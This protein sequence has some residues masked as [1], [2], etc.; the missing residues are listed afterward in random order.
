MND[1]T[2]AI[3]V[4]LYIEGTLVAA[5]LALTV[6]LIEYWPKQLFAISA[7]HLWSIF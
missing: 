1:V 7:D 6:L 3:K 2:E 4:G 5:I